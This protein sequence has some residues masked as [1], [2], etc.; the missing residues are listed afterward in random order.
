MLATAILARALVYP[1]RDELFLQ[2]T[3]LQQRPSVSSF[4]PATFSP[5]SYTRALL[6]LCRSLDSVFFARVLLICLSTPNSCAN[7]RGTLG[8]SQIF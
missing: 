8:A 1:G 5:A 7:M 4:M 6:S 2:P 3:V